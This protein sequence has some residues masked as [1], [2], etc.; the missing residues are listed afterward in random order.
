MTLHKPQFT[1][2]RLQVTSLRLS[3][4]FPG[5]WVILIL[6]QVVVL[7]PQLTSLG[8]HIARAR[9]LN[10]V[11]SD[12]QV[13][14]CLNITW[15]IVNQF[16]KTMLVSEFTWKALSNGV[17]PITVSLKVW[18]WQSSKDNY[19]NQQN[20]ATTYFWP[21]TSNFNKIFFSQQNFWFSAAMYPGSSVISHHTSSQSK[22]FFYS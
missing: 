6:P 16:Y 7:M 21:K 15:V 2:F 1:F 17:G 22:T 9:E 5:P 13:S 14:L 19:T 20:T 18:K 11:E 8:L 4:T 12:F 3:R 10:T